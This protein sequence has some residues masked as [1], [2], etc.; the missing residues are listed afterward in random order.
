MFAE[1]AWYFLC[2]H[3]ARLIR[4]ARYASV[5][6]ADGE[7][8]VRKRRRFYAPI[9]VQASRPVFRILGT[10]MRVL[11]HRE[12]V[13]R[14]QRIYRVLQRGV[15]LEEKGT[16]VLPMLPGR[17]LARLLDD[18]AVQEGDRR[19]AIELAVLALAALHREGI[20]HG[21]A[22]ADNVLV[23]LAAGAAHWIDFE[24]LHDSSRPEV[25]RRADDLRALLATCL[26]RT[27]EVDSEAVLA[28]LVDAY[29]DPSVERDLTERFASILQRSL[30]FHL[31]QAP[32][33][34]Q[35]FQAI[36]RGLETRALRRGAAALRNT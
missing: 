9:L 15:V 4:S 28:A 5:A 8:Q 17:S 18:P 31:G 3:A 1:R 11:A 26:L 36:A 20:F 27:P 24:T 10:G 35:R 22:M 23:D 13:A 2:L 14:E 32:L 30:A 6:L 29:P 19:R 34:R 7:R 33:P 12:W 21:D 16:L 25:W